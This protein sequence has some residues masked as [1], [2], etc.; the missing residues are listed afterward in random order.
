MVMV[1]LIGQISLIN[2][3]A[4]LHT[5]LMVSILRTAN[6]LWIGILIGVIAI[7]LIEW[8]LRK[9][10]ALGIQGESIREER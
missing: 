4:H 3:Y 8:A 10:R 2:T 1:G 5:P 9:V 6:G 7:L